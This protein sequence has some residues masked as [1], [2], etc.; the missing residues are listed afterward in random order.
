MPPAQA[1]LGLERARSAISRRRDV[2]DVDDHG[3]QDRQPHDGLAIRHVPDCR[4]R[5]PR[6]SGEKPVNARIR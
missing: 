4:D 6:A 2:L 5:A 3:S 1:D